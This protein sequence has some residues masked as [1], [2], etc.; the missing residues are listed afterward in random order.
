MGCVRDSVHTHTHTNISERGPS[1]KKCNA[2][3]VG[4]NI[5]DAPGVLVQGVH[6]PG[7]SS[8][9]HPSFKARGT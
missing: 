9:S 8:R 4:C 2:N 3:N 1:K 6:V 7:A 5:L